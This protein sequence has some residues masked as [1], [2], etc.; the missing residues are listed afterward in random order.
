MPSNK[1]I[2]HIGPITRDIK[3]MY[4]FRINFNKPETAQH[5]KEMFTYIIN[6][7]NIKTTSRMGY[8]DKKE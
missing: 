4:G 2:S 3:E 7:D 1:N 8:H 5:Y 6:S